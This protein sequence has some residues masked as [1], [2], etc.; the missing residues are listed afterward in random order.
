V[1]ISQLLL[2]QQRG[3]DGSWSRRYVSHLEDGSPSITG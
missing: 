3:G 1:R 2:W